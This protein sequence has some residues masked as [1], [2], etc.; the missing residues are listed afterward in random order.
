V[1]LDAPTETLVERIRRRGRREERH[2]DG[3]RLAAIRQA[4]LA[5]AEEPGHGPILRL[6]H[7]DTDRVSVEV[8]AAIDAMR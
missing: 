6:A 5:L 7:D 3:D 8:T 4:I 2:L 1:L